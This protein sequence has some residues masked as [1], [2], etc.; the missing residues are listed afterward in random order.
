MSY[1]QGAVP[2]R[3]HASL[4]I[5]LF[6]RSTSSPFGSGG[7]VG[8]PLTL[9]GGRRSGSEVRLPNSIEPADVAH[10]RGMLIECPSVPSFTL[11]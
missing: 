11:V 6:Q 9:A 8:T 2:T 5:W 7:Q 4:S 3:N 10:G 1:R